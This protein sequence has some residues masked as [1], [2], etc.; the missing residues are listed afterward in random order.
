LGLKL[1]YPVR[2]QGSS[3]LLLTDCAPNAEMVRIVFPERKAL[4]KV[5]MPRVEVTWYDGGIKPLKP[6]GW[7]AGKDINDD[8]GGVI[9]HGS[10]DKLICGCYGKDPWLLSGRV[11]QAPKV[12]RRIEISHE[13]DWVRA[14][15][16][17]PENRIP[18]ASP[19]S[20]AG[21]FNEMVVM[22]VLAVRLQG[23]NKELEWD[24]ENMRFTNISDADKL[25]ICIE[26]NFNITDGDPTFDKKWTDELSA[27]QFAEE[28]IKHNY[29]SGWSLPSMP[30]V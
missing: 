13:M 22:G 23:L 14:C 7:P 26:D 11:P 2:A 10:Q 18:T 1:K 30:A 9:F 5:K 15:K 17:N 27:K 28:L 4:K 3:T 12:L 29:R 6:N 19:F 16:E 20:D 21:P 8:G 24:G 25:R